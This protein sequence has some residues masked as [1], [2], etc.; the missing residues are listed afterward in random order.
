[1]C[2]TLSADPT[3]ERLAALSERLAGEAFLTPTVLNGVPAL[4]AAFSNWRTTE[5]DVH[6][7]AGSLRAAVRHA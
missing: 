3:A 4:R 5:A 7:I 2:F 1:M 6:H